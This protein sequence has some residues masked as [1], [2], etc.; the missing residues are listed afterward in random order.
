MAL[1]K[2]GLL[3]TGDFQLSIEML[4]PNAII[5]EVNLLSS[6]K[7]MCIELCYKSECVSAM[8]PGYFPKC[9]N[10]ANHCHSPFLLLHASTE[11]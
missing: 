10:P 9:A 3:P 5:R 11:T 7:R 6:L 1:Q 4:E 8:F 2:K